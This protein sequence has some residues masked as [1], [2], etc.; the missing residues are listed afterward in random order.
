MTKPTR[1][2]IFAAL[3]NFWTREYGEL[4]LEVHHTLTEP[5]CP[6]AIVRTEGEEGP[7]WR[8]DA[9]TIDDA[10]DIALAA[11][12]VTLVQRKPKPMTCPISDI[13][14]DVRLAN[15]LAAI[16]ARWAAHKT[17]D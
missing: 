15:F 16:D 4:E 10:I 14:E 2:E 5:S 3:G 17:S 6:T 12:Y 1:A 7:R 13:D 11:A 8:A 9:N